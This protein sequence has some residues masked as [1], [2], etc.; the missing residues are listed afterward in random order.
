MDSVHSGHLRK[1]RSASRHPSLGF[2]WLCLYRVS[3]E[4]G[5]SFT[6]TEGREIDRDV[7][8]K[9]CCLAFDYDTVLKSIAG[10]DDG[11]RDGFW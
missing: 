8:E 7:K 1:L 3:S 4:R 10:T 11:P 9:L 2:G 6:T 5:D